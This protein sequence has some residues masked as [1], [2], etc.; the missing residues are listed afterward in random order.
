MLQD[1]YCYHRHFPIQRW[2]ILERKGSIGKNACHVCAYNMF[3]DRN[4]EFVK[5]GLTDL[6]FVASEMVISITSLY[7]I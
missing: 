1:T 2:C 7:W 3:K 4:M 6:Y 5:K